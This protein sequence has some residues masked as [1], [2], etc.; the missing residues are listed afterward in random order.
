MKN[1]KKKQQ[2]KHLNLSRIAQARAEAVN[3]PALAPTSI[4]VN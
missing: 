1:R 3:F 4:A 2:T